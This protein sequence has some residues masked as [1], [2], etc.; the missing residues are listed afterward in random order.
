MK[1]YPNNFA[2]FT[3]DILSRG[4]DYFKRGLVTIISESKNE[5]VA[6]V[7][8]SMEN[9]YKVVLRF[10]DNRNLVDSD[11]SCPYLRPC[12]HKAAVLFAI[13]A[14]EIEAIRSDVV[15]IESDK[16]AYANTVI[17]A[18]YSRR[19]VELLRKA[20]DIIIESRYR[21]DSEKI[22][23][24]T[25]SL[26]R[27]MYGTYYYGSGQDVIKRCLI[28]LLDN[29]DYKY[30][31]FLRLFESCFEENDAFNNYSQGQLLEVL[32]RLEKYSLAAQEA[33][34]GSYYKDG[35]HALAVLSSASFES[36]KSDYQVFPP[37]AVL[38]IEA[39]PFGTN[40]SFYG[41]AL[42]EALNTADIGS[43]KKLVKHL[44]KTHNQSFIPE[45]TYEYLANRGY[46]EDLETILLDSFYEYDSD[47]ESYVR[48]R[49]YL[50][51][52][53][54]TELAPR[55]SELLTNKKYLNAVLLRDGNLFPE[56]LR[57]FSLKKLSSKEI[58]FCKEDLDESIKGEVIPLLR[59][60]LTDCK[61]KGKESTMDLFYALLYLDHVN[62]FYLSAAMF[63]P[64]IM[65]AVSGD[66]TL[67]SIWLGIVSRHDLWKKAGVI[68]YEVNYVSD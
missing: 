46:F 43:I 6:E 58:Y 24:L 55:I 7:K 14:K 41:K 23:N 42:Q 48:L 59:K 27:T 30:E 66:T 20:K 5:V 10:D 67:R 29:I 32:I 18:A 37:F 49:K 31:D 61:A 34:V 33:F 57:S 54:F 39:V 53:R 50:P 26:I 51:S 9:T 12:K 64:F 40:P 8:G 35:K 22:F 15:K 28:E 47:F 4:R 65:N 56:H 38:L 44:N 52:E 16:S 19:S 45:S 3:P 1:K 63:E 25:L 21:L 62:D 36:P 2:I 13:N 68:P 60:R 17:K 11:C